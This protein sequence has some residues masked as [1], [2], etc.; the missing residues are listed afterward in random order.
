MKT[1]DEVGHGGFP[2]A[3][4]SHERDHRAAG[5]RD[6]EVAH[7]GPAGAIFEVDVFEFDFVHDERSIPS[8]G[9]VRLVVAHGKDFED[10]FHGG[11]GTLKFRKGI[12]D[13]PNRIEQKEGVPLEGHDVA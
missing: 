10:S 5:Y 8:V 6:V 1:R 4:A 3:T 7:D 13:V 11:K 12:D 2:G 9:F